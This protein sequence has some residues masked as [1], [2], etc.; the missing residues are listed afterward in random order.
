[1]FGNF[2]FDQPW[3][4][5]VPPGARAKWGWDANFMSAFFGAEGR[6]RGR[7]RSGRMF[8][9]GD[10]RYVVLPMRPKGTRDWSEQELAA[11]VTRDNMIGTAIPSAPGKPKAA[12]KKKAA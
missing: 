12:K 10:L 3:P 2:C 6:S 7:W 1:M 11:L 5:H 8:E 9:Q 4:G